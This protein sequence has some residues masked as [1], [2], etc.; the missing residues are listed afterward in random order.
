MLEQNKGQ[1]K[2]LFYS[3]NGIFALGLLLLAYFVP[4]EASFP[5]IGILLGLFG[6]YFF[7]AKERMQWRFR[8]ILLGAILL[9]AILLFATPELSDDYYR[10]LWDGYLT[11]SGINPYFFT[12]SEI[13]K[14]GHTEHAYLVK[15]MNSPDYYSVYPALNQYVFSFCAYLSFDSYRIA[16]GLM[17][18]LMFGSEIATMLLLGALLRASRIKRRN[19]IWYT[20]NPLVI[21]EFTGSLH[22]EGFMLLFIL[23]AIWWLRVRKIGYAGVSLALAVCL[24]IIPLIFIP[25][26][27]RKIPVRK[28]WLFILSGLVT[29]VILFYPFFDDL[30]VLNILDSINLYFGK[31][32]F[33]SSIYRLL[34]LTDLEANEIS[35]ALKGCFILA[36]LLVLIMVKKKF[37]IPVSLLFVYFAY[38]IFSQSVHPWYILP[39]IAY[40]LFARMYFPVV[41]SFFAAF[42]Y[43]TYHDP[44]NY[45]QN[46]WV[47][48]IEYTALIGFFVYE[49]WVYHSSKRDRN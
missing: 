39:L 11:N 40:G 23:L 5:T 33:N 34:Q 25:F 7:L 47:I 9:R 14:Q 45:L 18:V 48:L 37:P 10:F 15:Q 13:I 43:Y 2:K 6:L 28:W 32:E 24:K 1:S 29:V 17:K 22:F 41:W 19:A 27:L 4:R 49:M 38:L 16:I 44:N 31:F 21:M 12:P 42:T 30:V 35:W 46:P 36:F 20:H 26:F 3:L 8:T